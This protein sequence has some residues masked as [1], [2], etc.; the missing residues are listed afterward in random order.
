MTI[1]PSFK[2]VP[3]RVQSLCGISTKRERD[4]IESLPAF[5]FSE[6]ALDGEIELLA[7]CSRL[8]VGAGAIL[9][10]AGQNCRALEA[11]IRAADDKAHLIV[12]AT[13]TIEAEVKSATKR[14]LGTLTVL[15]GGLADVLP[16]IKL[17]LNGSRVDMVVLADVHETQLVD[18]MR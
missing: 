6:S 10:V 15:I 9:F 12:I 2:I 16:E 17:A 7:R 3:I 8:A 1:P 13:P 5:A 11:L 4:A 18:I 14:F